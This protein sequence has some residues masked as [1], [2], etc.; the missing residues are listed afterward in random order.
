VYRKHTSIITKSCQKTNKAPNGGLFLVQIFSDGSTTLG[1]KKMTYTL[2]GNRPIAI[3]ALDTLPVNFALTPVNQKRP[4]LTNWQSIDTSR[5]DIAQHLLSGQADG[6]GIKLG[7]PSNGIC[8]IDI[9]GTAARCKLFDIM[10]DEEM[11]LTVE[12]ASGKLDRSQYLFTIPASLWNILKTKTEKIEGE[13]F[14]FFWTGRQSVL[15]PSAHPE[16]K[17]YFWVHSPD[18]TAIAPIPDKLLAYWLNLISPAYSAPEPPQPVISVNIPKPTKTPNILTIPLERLLTKQH[19]S[20]L[21]GVSQGG[22]NTTGASLARDLI[23]VAGLGQIEC[24]YRGKDYILTIEGDPEDL[25][26]DYCDGCT[27]P[28]AANESARIWQSAKSANPAPAIRDFDILVNCG[29]AYLKESLP[30]RGRPS[31]SI[32]QVDEVDERKDYQQ[33]G[34]KFGINLAN[35]DLNSFGIP[36]SKLVML[37]L[38]L[39]DLFGN[40]LQFNEM[41]REIELDKEPIDLNMAKHFVAVA[42]KYDASTES[43]ILALNAIATKFKYHPVREYLESLRGKAT[44]LDLIANFPATYFGNSDELQNRLFFRKLVASVARVMNPGTKDD[45]LLVLQG[46]QGAG[47]ST[48]LKA[49][50]GDDWFNDDLRSLDDKDEIAKLSRFWFLELAE[51][52][53]LFGKKEVEQFKRFLSCT[54][55]TF[56]PPYGRGNILVKRSCALFAST[57]KSEFLTDPTGDRR[58]W[59]VQVKQNIDVKGIRRDRDLIWATALAAYESGHQHFLDETERSEHVG[60]SKQWHDDD[61]WVDTILPKLGKVLRFH[62]GLEYVNIQEIM[63]LILEIPVE[64]QDKRQR[65]RIAAMLQVEGFERLVR[66]IEGK[67]RKIW[68]RANSSNLS[69]KDELVVESYTG[70]GNNLSNL[71][72]LSLNIL[73]I[74]SNNAENKGDNG[75]L[76]INLAVEQKDEYCELDWLGVESNAV[77]VTVSM[78]NSLSNLSQS[79]GLDGLGSASDGDVVVPVDASNVSESASVECVEINQ[80]QGFETPS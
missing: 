54:E 37:E 10:G 74:N 19:R 45:S 43:C 41:S 12:F 64:R 46:K 29:R 77:E 63:D 51:V 59:V 52:D 21:S 53:Y 36:I 68:G 76:F 32:H 23:G 42:L 57:N 62:G 8:A 56:R 28:L 47:K 50:A 58:Y 35:K 9:D 14:A 60:A 67:P 48:A 44:N 73:E 6:Y 65:N 61:P 66:T 72:N 70:S 7:I 30:K 11:P 27:P 18:D 5:S 40:R 13:E 4:Y 34:R 24:D 2:N 78:A 39:F 1:A 31:K 17:G 71:S 15:P 3:A 22:R 55:D 69:V 80:E 49:L 38:D 33:I 79:D 75:A 26:Y 16:T 25:F 20:I